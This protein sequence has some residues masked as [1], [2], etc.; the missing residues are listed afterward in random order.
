V[1][2][3][4]TGVRLDAINQRPS[5]LGAQIDFLEAFEQFETCKHSLL[6]WRRA[7]SSNVIWVSGVTDLKKDV[8]RARRNDSTIALDAAVD[9]LDAEPALV[10]GLVGELLLPR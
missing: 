3:G 5:L 7:T 8:K 10:Q 4:A 2:L 9:M 1:I 6:R